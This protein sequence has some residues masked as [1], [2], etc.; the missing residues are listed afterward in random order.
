M[1]GQDYFT[2]RLSDIYEYSRIQYKCGEGISNKNAKYLWELCVDV[3]GNI[4]FVLSSKE[5]LHFLDHNTNVESFSGTSND[6]VWEIN[7]TDIK[8]LT[9]KVEVPHKSTWFCLPSTVVLKLKGS[10]IMFLLWLEL[11]LVTLIFLALIVNVDSL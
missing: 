10:Q 7:C 5:Y 6:E 1:L 9:I 4:I 3:S 8:I 2:I 11:T